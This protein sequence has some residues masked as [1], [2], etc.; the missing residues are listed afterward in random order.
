MFYINALERT[1]FLFLPKLAVLLAGAGEQR[2]NYE[3]GCEL[4]H[5]WSKA[6]LRISNVE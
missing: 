6:A 2:K 5:A 1:Y 3:C 4:W